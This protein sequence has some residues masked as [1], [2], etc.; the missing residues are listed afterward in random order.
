MLIIKTMLI[1]D[2]Y[3]NGYHSDYAD[4]VDPSDHVNLVDQADAADHSS[5]TD[6]AVP[7]WWLGWVTGGWNE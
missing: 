7:A 3:D 5:H 2:H 4:H 1:V 6:H